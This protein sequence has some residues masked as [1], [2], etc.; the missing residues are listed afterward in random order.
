M[1]D[2]NPLAPWTKVLVATTI[3]LVSAMAI[4]EPA[5]AFFQTTQLEGT[6][7][8]KTDGVWL[9]VS[10]MMPTFRVRL[11][12]GEKQIAPFEVGPIPEDLKPLFG[13]GTRGVIVTKFEDKTTSQRIGIFEG[14]VIVKVNTVEV[15]SV[16]EFDAALQD[17]KSWFLITIQRTKL[18]ISSARIIKFK[19]ETSQ[20]EE[21]GT[22]VMGAQKVDVHIANLVLPFAK[23]LEATRQSHE[24]YTPSPETLEKLEENWWTLEQVEP[25]AF[26]GGE[27]RV[28]AASDYDSSLRQDPLMEGSQLAVISTL[29]GNP[30]SGSGGQVISIYGIREIGDDTM[31]GSIVE[32]TIASAPFP[33][34]I[35]FDGAFT[36]YRLGDY[37]NKDLEHLA[38]TAKQASSGEDEEGRAV[39]LAPDIPDVIPPENSEGAEELAD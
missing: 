26:V 12:R 14:D 20:V 3:C 27:H 8:L 11:D 24:F 9:A 29:K 1:I 5:D 28:V 34:S 17:T 21:N 31:S 10:Q 23:E 2:Q 39:E 30:L 19:T 7:P 35:E 33:I 38:E 16:E 15:S 32:S 25:P 18:A 13:E 37:S 4:A 22:T 6:V 36:M